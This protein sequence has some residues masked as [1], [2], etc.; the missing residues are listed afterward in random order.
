MSGIIEECQSTSY[1][2][3]SMYVYVCSSTTSTPWNVKSYVS[4]RKAE[5]HG[6]NGVLGTK[7]LTFILS[8][9]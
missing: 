9:A 7:I 6:K 1:T 4:S 3:C 8:T 5:R 2:T